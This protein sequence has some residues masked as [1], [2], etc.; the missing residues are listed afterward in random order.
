MGKKKMKWL[1]TTAAVLSIVGGLV[2]ILQPFNFDLL[3]IF[4]SYGKWV[5]LVAGIA[6]VVFIGKKLMKK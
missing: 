1:W 5:Q 4:G 2:H 3:G 6:T